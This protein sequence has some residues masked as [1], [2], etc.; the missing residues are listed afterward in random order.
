MK[1]LIV[2]LTIGACLLLPSAGVVF[3][4]K[5]ESPHGSTG[6]LAL[7][8]GKGAAPN[9]QPGTG[10]GGASCGTLS[11]G[12]AGGPPGQLVPGGNG[13]MSPFALDISGVSKNYAGSTTNIVNPGNS[14]SNFHANSQYD[15][16]CFHHQ[17]P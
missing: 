5:M 13:S 6:P 1:H 2:S 17:V 14:A 7:P 12:M 11:G 4:G 15:V 16:A 9:G 10:G 3:A 8:G